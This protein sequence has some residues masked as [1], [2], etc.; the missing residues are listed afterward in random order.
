MRTAYLALATIL[1]LVA[2][3]ASVAQTDQ[4]RLQATVQAGPVVRAG[5]PS[6]ADVFVGGRFALRIPA[7]AGGMSPMQRAQTIADRMNRAF[8]AGMSWEDMRVSQVK[9]LWTVCIDTTVIA[10]ADRNSA[11]AFRVSTGNLASSWARQTVVALGGQPQ[12]IAMQLQPI[13]VAVA[14]AREELMVNWATS[15]TKTLP[16]L[17]AA[18]GATIG[19]VVVGGPSDRLN[20]A[21]AVAMYEYSAD[22]AIVRVFVPIRETSTTGTLSR[23]H[24]VGLVGIPAGMLPMTGLRMGADVS[25]MVTQMGSKWNDTI[26]SRLTQLNL[27]THADTKVAPLYSMDSKQVVGAAQIMGMRRGVFPAQMVVCTTSDGM[28]H[29]RATS[30]AY[31]PMGTPA[32]LNEVVV[33]ALIHVPQ[34]AETAPCEEP[35]PPETTSPEPG[36]EEM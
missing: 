31:P 24:G 25:D 23:A 18:T 27:Q 9:G 30:T 8:A 15:P 19:N 10:T 13:P 3:G 32:E 11:R 35:P 2:A 28:I 34:P 12:M 22:S 29:F 4:Q 1:L 16:L 20:M 6:S 17:N 33:S 26:N 5:L 14:G 21:N 7:S 36:D